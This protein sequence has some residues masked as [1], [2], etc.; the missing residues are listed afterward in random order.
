MLLAVPYESA[1]LLFKYKNSGSMLRELSKHRRITA[2]SLAEMAHVGVKTAWSLLRSLQRVECVVRDGRFF[3]ATDAL[4]D[5]S[6]II[7]LRDS[8][9]DDIF[10]YNVTRRILFSLATKKHRSFAKMARDLQIPYVTCI[11]V[12]NMLRKSGLMADRGLR[13]GLIR[14]ASNPLQLIP[15]SAHRSAAEHFLQALKTYYP[16]FSEPLILFGD[17]SWGKPSLS[18][19]IL[20]L[21]ELSVYPEKLY[22]FARALVNAASV[23]TG[24]FGAA[25]DLN[26][27]T[28]DAWLAQ[29]LKMVRN[30]HP[31][32]A[33]AFEG[34]CIHGSLPTFKDFFEFMNRA[35]PVEKEKVAEWLR[36]GYV[37]IN[38]QGRY[39]FTERA[40]DRWRKKPSEIFEEKVKIEGRSI[41]FI[42]IKP[43]G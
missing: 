22:V 18:I 5:D 10:R 30:P 26:I 11:A 43:P 31:T 17:A 16:E 4:Q 24:S 25:V 14:E 27:T 37:R 6:I 41:S 19:D 8:F 35:R 33:M 39:V 7:N 20:A 13:E 2:S 36:K 21:S 42:G 1:S 3:K 15:R 34:I 40:L 9:Y 29:E 32:L 23:V 38:E 12:V 28:K